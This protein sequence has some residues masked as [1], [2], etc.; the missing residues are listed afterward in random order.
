MSFLWGGVAVEHDPERAEA[1][2]RLKA[3]EKRAEQLTNALKAKVRAKRPPA[4]NA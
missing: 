4:Y 1:V 3:L 2:Q